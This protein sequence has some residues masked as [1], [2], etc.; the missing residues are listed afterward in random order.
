MKNPDMRT[1]RTEHGMQYHSSFLSLDLINWLVFT[2]SLPQ[3][4][5]LPRLTASCEKEH[6]GCWGQV[7]T[8]QRL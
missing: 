8:T 2:P 1:S 7:V 3:P 5:H 4:E 6:R